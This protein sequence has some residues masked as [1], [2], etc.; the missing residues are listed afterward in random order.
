MY[1]RRVRRLERCHIPIADHEAL[2]SRSARLPKLR[3]Y[4]LRIAVALLVCVAIARCTES[5]LEQRDFEQLTKGE[6]FAEVKGARIRYRLVSSPAKAPL[7][8][9]VNGLVGIREQWEELQNEIADFAPSLAYDRG[10]SG[11]SRGAYAHSASEQAD[12]LFDLLSALHYK[13]RVFI[14]SYSLSGPIAFMLMH[15][16]GQQLAGAVLLEPTLPDFTKYNPNIRSPR[17]DLART[18]ISSNI[19]T[20]LGVRRLIVRAQTP[21]PKPIRDRRTDAVLVGFPHWQS[22]FREWLAWPESQRQA[23]AAKLPRQLPVA[24]LAGPTWANAMGSDVRKNLD[25]ALL[26]QTERGS[27]IELD[28]PDHARLLSSLSTRKALIDALHKMVDEQL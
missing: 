2:P 27:Y 17:R 16:Y 10:G 5:T 25:D 15:K 9:F 7:V 11:F 4:A 26:G 28:E 22:I 18:V 1:F 14:V 21:V 19:T 8:V 3:R 13:G 6:T 24:V 20:F 12:E 23:A